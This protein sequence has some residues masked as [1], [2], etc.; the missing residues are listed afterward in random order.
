MSVCESRGYSRGHRNRICTVIV[1]H[2]GTLRIIFPINTVFNK[3]N[4][5][6]LNSAVGF[7]DFLPSSLFTISF[8]VLL[9]KF[10]KSFL[11]CT[12]IIY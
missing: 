8:F 9:L 7:D 3:K 10:H 12:N 11:K 2:R 5:A 6:I 4:L 1:T